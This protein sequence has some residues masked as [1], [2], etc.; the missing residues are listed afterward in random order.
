MEARELLEIM[1]VAEKLK[2]ATRHCY[3]SGGRWESVAEHSWRT[4]L[5]AYF[6]SSEFPE[7]NLEKLLKMCLIHDM[8][9]AF[10]GDIRT[11]LPLEYS[12]QM[13]YG[14]D[15][16][17]FSDYLKK[18]RDEVREDSK[19]KIAEKDTSISEQMRQR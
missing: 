15:K 16:A 8:G 14:N 11:W 2:D 6:V 5:M 7:A 1:S 9:E 10:T 3:T 17:E 19:K 18:L 4:A 12:L 13:T